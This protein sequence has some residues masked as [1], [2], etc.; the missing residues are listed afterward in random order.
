MEARKNLLSPL[1]RKQCEQI[2]GRPDIHGLRAKALLAL[3]DGVSQAEA[4][5]QTSLSSGQVRYAVTRFRKI[6]LD[7]FPE[8][9]LAQ[10]TVDEEQESV[11]SRAAD[12][13]APVEQAEDIETEK[14]AEAETTEAPSSKK[15][16][17]PKKKTKKPK[18]DKKTKKDKAA[19]KGKKKS[20]KGEKDKQSKKKRKKPKKDKAA[21]K[22]KKKSAKK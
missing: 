15:E 3:D 16:K 20:D 9:L 19:E 17:K 8:E 21:K 2:A 5:E 14:E 6:G 1:D 13:P 11:V 12:V 10:A 7:M 18:K 4:A 22:G